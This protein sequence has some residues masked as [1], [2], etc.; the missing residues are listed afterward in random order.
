MFGDLFFELFGISGSISSRLRPGRKVIY[1]FRKYS[2]RIYGQL[3]EMG[4]PE[5][6]KNL[7]F[8]IPKAI[9]EVKTEDPP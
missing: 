5:G 7:N 3:K 2:K 1:K 8:R 9:K 6:L 4:F